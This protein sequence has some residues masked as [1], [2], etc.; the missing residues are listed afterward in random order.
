MIDFN[1][2]GDLPATPRTGNGDHQ[3]KE[4]RAAL[5]TRLES[6]LLSIFPAGKVRRGK[7]HIGDVLGSPGDSLEIVLDSEKAGLWTDRATGDAGESGSWRGSY[8]GRRDVRTGHQAVSRAYRFFT[9]VLRL[10][11]LSFT[12]GRLRAAF[13]F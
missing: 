12:D 5:L 9:L 1:D 4:I 2:D 7:F 3:R 8:R 13:S 6:A 11:I 10:A